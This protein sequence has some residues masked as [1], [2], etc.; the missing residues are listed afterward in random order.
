MSTPTVRSDFCEHNHA[1]VFDLVLAGVAPLS[2]LGKKL[3]FV[4]INDGEHTDSCLKLYH[5]KNFVMHANAIAAFVNHNRKTLQRR[6]NFEKEVAQLL[7]SFASTGQSPILLL[8]K[9]PWVARFPVVTK[10]IRR[11]KVTGDE[12]HALCA[13]SL[14][15]S[16][17][18][19]D[20]MEITFEE[21]ECAIR[22]IIEQ[23]RS[24]ICD[25][26]VPKTHIFHSGSAI[27]ALAVAIVNLL[28]I[29]LPE[30]TIVRNIVSHLFP[31]QTLAV[32]FHP[33][34]L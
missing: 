1:H 20:Q 3:R 12:A 23:Y 5:M 15:N 26:R 24:W 16:Q 25:R 11:T 30:E 2:V 33:K 6:R 27:V 14:V 31:P 29:K 8:L 7:A 10:S 28:R 18:K 34:Y 19:L 13:L 17:E 9:M 32:I 21:H 22:P 4:C